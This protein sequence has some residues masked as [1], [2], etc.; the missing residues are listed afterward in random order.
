MLEIN[1][2][3]HCA[4]V[5]WRYAERQHYYVADHAGS[6]HLIVALWLSQHPTIVR[7][8]GSRDFVTP[9]FLTAVLSKR[10]VPLI[11]RTNKNISTI[12]DYSGTSIDF[13]WI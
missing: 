2:I 6:A 4:M 8:G 3:V 12:D 1:A 9:V 13:G 11:I 5:A 10:N 7:N